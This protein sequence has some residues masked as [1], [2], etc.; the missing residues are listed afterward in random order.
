MKIATCHRLSIVLVSILLSSSSFAQICI[1]T[2]MAQNIGN[3]VSGHNNVGQAFTASCAGDITSVT[4]WFNVDPNTGTNL[5]D[6]VLHIRDGVLCTS[7][8]L[9]TETIPIGSLAAGA[10]VFILSTPVPIN[11]GEANSFEI[12]D[13]GQ[14]PDAAYG[15]SHNFVGLYLGG[16]AWFS[17][18]PLASYDLTFEVT[19]WT[20]GS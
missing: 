20:I 1:E 12:T 2:N 4:V 18:N 15:V 5:N 14:T 9:H 3:Y 10:N 19:S 17:C 13:V 7:P 11:M 16:D 6:R 8:I